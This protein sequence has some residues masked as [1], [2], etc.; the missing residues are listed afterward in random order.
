MLNYARIPD[1]SSTNYRSTLRN[2]REDL[3]YTAAEASN[4]DFLLARFKHLSLNRGNI[5]ASEVWNFV[6][7]FLSVEGNSMLQG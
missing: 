2:I 3:V 7:L 4:D 1:T 5:A 6:T